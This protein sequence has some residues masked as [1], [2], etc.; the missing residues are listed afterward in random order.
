M[1]G[2]GEAF[3]DALVAG[4]L[5]LETA[6]AE[7]QHHRHEDGLELGGDERG[8]ATVGHGGARALP[9]ML[10]QEFGQGGA[11]GEHQGRVGGRA[12]LEGLEIVIGHL[13]IA[14]IGR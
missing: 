4:L 13:E 2:A 8:D 12:F 11:G 10:G 7:A 6:R 1:Q 3:V 14:E 9:V 5:G